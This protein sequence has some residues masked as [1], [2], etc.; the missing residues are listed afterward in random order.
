[1]DMGEEEAPTTL[2]WLGIGTSHFNLHFNLPSYHDIQIKS[3]DASQC[4]CIMRHE[5]E[6][7]V[8]E[9]MQKNL[10]VSKKYSDLFHKP[11]FMTEHETAIRSEPSSV[12]VT[13]QCVP[14]AHPNA[15][16]ERV[17]PLLN[18][19]KVNHKMHILPSSQRYLLEASLRHE[20]TM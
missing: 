15:L 8:S 20:P 3:V 7:G 4:S 16:P 18:H 13:L 17:Y 11:A 1:M 6:D 2:A 10:V 5:V 14:Y 9:Y 12:L 19:K